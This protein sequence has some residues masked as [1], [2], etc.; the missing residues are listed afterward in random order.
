MTRKIFGLYAAITVLLIALVLPGA[1]A[2]SVSEQSGYIT[3]G[4]APL[5]DF[6]ALYAYNVVPTNVAFRDLSTGTTPMKYL[7][8]FGDGATSTEQNPSH[9]Y[10]RQGLYTVKLT[11]TNAYGSSTE[12]KE[13]YVAVGLAP[14]ADFSAEPTM[15]NTP[16]TV[17]FTDRSTGHPTSWNWNF[18]DGKESVLPNPVHT[19]WTSGEYTV[20]LTAT[21]QYGISDTSKVNF[22]HVKPPLAAKFTADPKAGKVP[23]LVK[24][25]DMSAGN[26]ESWDW[27]FGDGSTSDQANPVHAYTSPGAFHVSLTVKSG[28]YRDTATQTIVAGGGPSTDFVADIT[29]VGVNTPVHFTDKTLNSPISWSWNFG[30]GATSPEQNPT[31]EYAVKGIYTVTLTT[32]NIDGSDTEV[33]A[34][35]ITVGLAPIADFITQIP[36]YQ[37]GTRMQF[38]RFIDQSTGNPASWLWDFGDGTT[39]SEQYPPLHLYNVDG[40]YTVS[41]TAKNI[42]GQN[43]MVK[44]GLITVQ[45]GPTVDFKADRTRVGVDQWIHFTDLSTNNPTDWKW[46]FGDG[47]SGTGQNPDHVYHQPGSYDV[48]LIA[49]DAFTTTSQTKKDYITVIN[50]P[51]A[52]FKADKTKG[53]TPF[54]V[55]FTDISTG[56]PKIWSWDFGDGATSTDQNPTHVY[57]TKGTAATNTFTVTLTVTN[58]NGQDTAKKTDYITVTQTPIAEFTVDSRQG[59]APFVVQFRDLSAGNPTSWSWEFGDGTG[60]SEQNPSHTYPYEGAYDVRLT[61]SNGFG[62]DTVIKTGS[63]SQRGSAPPVSLTTVVVEKTTDVPVTTSQP[64]ATTTISKPVPT[65][66]KSPLPPVITIVASVIA[67]LI[68]SS[69][70]RR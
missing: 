8:E 18:G 37:Q 16:L 11:V 23:L 36:P 48:T 54:T 19:Y 58:A 12:T 66:T 65:T 53:I 68:I 14:K 30:D 7:W 13:N 57:T 44:T 27:D 61:V 9:N 46:E 41:L 2:A 32:T 10:I 52:D 26:P 43:T 15:G 50:T 69:I 47:T 60:S 6:D 45:K 39:S 35:Y 62:S 28:M 20:T 24:F 34:N 21:N 25:T 59:K 22:I 3:V 49:S 29:T 51:Q 55:Q 63:T 31:H 70:K 56:T 4:I 1:S 40:T 33:K 5:A 64:A 17:A 67:L 42:F 38:V